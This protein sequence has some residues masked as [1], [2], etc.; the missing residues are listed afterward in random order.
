MRRHDCHRIDDL[1]EQFLP[2]LVEVAGDHD[3]QVL[4]VV[5]QADVF[6]LARRPGQGFVGVPAH[7]PEHDALA[8]ADGQGRRRWRFRRW[9]LSDRGHGQPH[10]A[11]MA[12]PRPLVSRGGRCAAL[13]GVSLGG[14]SYPTNSLYFFFVPGRNAGSRPVRVRRLARPARSLAVRPPEG[15]PT[16][17]IRAP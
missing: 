5:G 12:G 3:L 2:V 6:A 13:R 11:M 8:A 10:S 7:A 15:R 4:S 17:R 9:C 14:R 1:G 16:R